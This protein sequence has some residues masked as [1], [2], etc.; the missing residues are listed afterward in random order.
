M[1]FMFKIQENILGTFIFFIKINL[2]LYSRVR[3]S[4]THLTL[5]G[6]INLPSFWQSYR[7]LFQ[8]C[9]YI[10]QYL[11]GIVG[12]VKVA[13]FWWGHSNNCKGLFVL[14]DRGAANLKKNIPAL[15]VIQQLLQFDYSN[16]FFC[17][18]LQCFQKSTSIHVKLV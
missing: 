3:K 8:F 17:D 1:Y 15:D 18:N 12:K 13:N 11:T 9:W 14:F 16:V 5:A 10:F 6:I 7:S 2:I 4:T